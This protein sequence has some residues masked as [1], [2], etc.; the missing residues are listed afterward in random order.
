L[1][2]DE[3]AHVEFGHCHQLLTT[4][5]LPAERMEAGHP[6][7]TPNPT[8]N[9]APGCETAAEDQA[10]AADLIQTSKNPTPV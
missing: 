9:L 10:D 6:V 2:Q 8:R 3:V 7:W 4:A 5:P 1:K